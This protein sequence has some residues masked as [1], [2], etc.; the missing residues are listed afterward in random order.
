MNISIASGSVLLIVLSIASPCLCEWPP[1]LYGALERALFNHTENFHNLQSL[2]YPSEFV[3]T[4]SV[5]IKIGGCSLGVKNI[6]DLGPVINPAFIKCP[7]KCNCVGC[8]C[9]FKSLDFFLFDATADPYSKLYNYVNTRAVKEAIE[10][11]HVASLHLL[12]YLTHSQLH[13]SNITQ[14][15]FEQL[16][17]EKNINLFIEEELDSMP[18]YD[19]LIFDITQLLSWVSTK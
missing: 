3:R 2:L 11:A 13:L 8:Y 12:N 17:H 1:P 10:F 15:H 18:N 16:Y 14:T 19:A 7:S 6:T 9:T 4:Y 5:K